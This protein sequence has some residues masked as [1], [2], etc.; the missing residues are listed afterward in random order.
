MRW[1]LTLLPFLFT[2][3][4]SSCD[5]SSSP[6]SYRFVYLPVST[7]H[8]AEGGETGIFRYS[9]TGGGDPWR[10]TNV[11]SDYLTGVAENGIVLTA[12]GDGLEHRYWGKC[13]NGTLIPVP[14]PVSPDP[15]FEY[16]ISPGTHLTLSHD[17]H[18]AAWAMVRATASPSRRPD[19]ALLSL[20]NCAKWESTLL[21]VS[22]FVTRSVPNAEGARITGTNLLISPDG[23]SVI[24]AAEALRYP[25]DT[26]ESLGHLILE[27]K[28]DSLRVLGA[29]HPSAPTLLSRDALSRTCILVR[30]GTTRILSENGSEQPIPLRL[31]ELGSPQQNAITRSEIVVWRDDAIQ[32]RSPVTGDLLSTVVTRQ[33]LNTHGPFWYDLPPALSISPDGEWIAMSLIRLNADMTR[34]WRTVLACRRDGSGLTVL[35]SKVRAGVP[36]LSGILTTPQ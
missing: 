4:F 31:T 33:T 1:L 17:G 9:L 8:G 25:T 21:E 26:P 7:A 2:L 16:R 23:R 19:E 27:A 12:L 20:F 34:P 35:A 22:A 32:L 10:L 6:S 30:E 15:T 3:F 18:H 14:I 36:V 13:T 11:S 5:S 29:L 24:F 28:N